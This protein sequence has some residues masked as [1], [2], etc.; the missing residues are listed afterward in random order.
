MRL[1]RRLIRLFLLAIHLFNGALLAILFSR[2]DE[3]GFISERFNRIAS[4]WHQ[5]TADFLPIDIELKGE[6]PDQACL[7]VANHV[8]WL[9][10]P[11]IVANAPVFFLSKSEVRDWPVIGW[12]AEKGGTLFI[13][14]GSRTAADDSI[15]Q[16]AHAL[17][18]GHS[19]LI[20]PE[21]T[22]TDGNAVKRFHPRLFTA[23]QIANCPIQPVTLCYPGK[24]GVTNPVAPYINQD[25]FDHSLWRILAEPEIPVQVV[26]GPLIDP[27]DKERKQL[28]TEAQEQIETTLAELH[29]SAR[30]S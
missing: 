15:K 3:H 26:I 27:Q 13:Q 12:L 30:Q 22:T 19:V 28:A 21:G 29:L 10:I 2:R 20:F 4:K 6:I 18:H 8:S 16:I 23:A 17:N 11:S 24:D 7:Y 9:D 14:R 25:R 1:I 5:G